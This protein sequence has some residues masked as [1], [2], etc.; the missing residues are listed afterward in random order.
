MSRDLTRSPQRDV[1]FHVRDYEDRK[2]LR[3]RAIPTPYRGASA[4]ANLMSRRYLMSLMTLNIGR[5]N[6]MI[7]PPMQTPI[8]TI[9][10]GS[11]SDVIALTVASTSWS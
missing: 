11:I 4:R 8:T 9:S 7:M 6:A 1:A 5:Y 10:N 2:M 3:E